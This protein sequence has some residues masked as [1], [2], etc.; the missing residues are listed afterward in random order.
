MIVLPPLTD[1]YSE[2]FIV[3]LDTT[4]YIT[5]T[6]VITAPMYFPLPNIPKDLLLQWS[7]GYNG[8]YYEKTH[9]TH[10]VLLL[11]QRYD[12]YIT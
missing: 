10:V 1:L 4:F 8:S 3:G 2:Y 7:S 6:V 12:L 5:V 11:S 9:L